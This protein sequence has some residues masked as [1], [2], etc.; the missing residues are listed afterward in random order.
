MDLK[1]L[2]HGSPVHFVLFCQLPA[3]NRYELKVGK[4]ITCK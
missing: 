1:G 4:E 3:L 2:Y